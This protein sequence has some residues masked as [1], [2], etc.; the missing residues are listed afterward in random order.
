MHPLLSSAALPPS[1]HDLRCVTLCRPPDSL[2]SSE[3]VQWA[4]AKLKEKASASGQQGSAPIQ[5]SSPHEA[6]ERPVN[7]R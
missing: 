7:E 2:Y 3:A 5:P 1:A 6:Q 4:W